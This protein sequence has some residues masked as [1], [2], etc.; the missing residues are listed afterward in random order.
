MP[1]KGPIPESA[2]IGKSYPVYTHSL[3][4][5]LF[6]VFGHVALVLHWQV[7]LHM[8][9]VGP[10]Q[11]GEPLVGRC[12]K[13]SQ[14]E[15]NQLWGPLYFAT[16]PFVVVAINQNRKP[17]QQWVV[18]MN[19]NLIMSTKGSVVHNAYPYQLCVVQA[20]NFTQQTTLAQG[21]IWRWLRRSTYVAHWLRRLLRGDKPSSGQPKAKSKLTFDFQALW[22]CFVQVPKGGKGKPPRVFD[23]TQQ[24]S[25]RVPLP[26][27]AWDGCHSSVPRLMLLTNLS[28]LQPW[29]E[30]SPALFRQQSANHDAVP[31]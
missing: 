5:L 24:W 6:C 3:C 19:P 30:I 17:P 27:W 14:K 11:N 25:T 2:P 21:T 28:V 8:P 20:A 23:H 16:H 26:Q 13:G 7:L 29:P 31:S 12:S 22:L 9:H 1:W 4:I 10:S 15:V 18:D